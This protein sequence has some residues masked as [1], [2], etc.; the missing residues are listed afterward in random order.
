[1]AHDHGSSHHHDRGGHRHRHRLVAAFALIASVFVVELVVALT[2]GSLALLSDAGHMA[3]DAAA[4]GIAAAAVHLAERGGTR[5]GR[6][7]GLYR[8]EVLAALLNAV[9]L[10]VVA[11][12]VLW[13]AVARLRDG[14]AIDTGPVMIAAAVGLAANIIAFQLLREGAS[15]SVNVEAAYTEVLADLFGSIGVLVATAT[16]AVT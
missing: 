5:S 1:M 3:T 11:G 13:E 15:E 14:Q 7:F 8:L 10:F 4:L 2:T 16:I 12:W 6:S 9:L